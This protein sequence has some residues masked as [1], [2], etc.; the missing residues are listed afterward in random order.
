VQLPVRKVTKRASAKRTT[1]KSAPKLAQ[2][3][4]KIKKAV[5]RRGQK[6]LAITDLNASEKPLSTL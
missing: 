4:K 1:R 6:S 2:Q 3:S 5:S